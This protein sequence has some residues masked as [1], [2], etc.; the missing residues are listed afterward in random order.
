MIY[1]IIGIV[2]GVV[3]LY[4]QFRIPEEDFDIQPEFAPVG[5]GMLGVMLIVG[6][7]IWL[8]ILLS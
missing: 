7:S 4:A 3:L 5:L 8:L 1:P 6:S 2:I